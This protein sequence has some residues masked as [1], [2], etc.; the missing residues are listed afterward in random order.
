[1]VAAARDLIEAQGYFGTGVNRVLADSGAPRGSLYFHFPE[2]KDRLVADALEEGGREVDGL[3]AA[4][5]HGE[6]DAASLTRRLLGVLADRM[7][8]SSYD[9]GCPV[10]TVALEVSGTPERGGNERLRE[11]CARIYARWERALAD[12]L[13]AEG[14]PRPEAE[15][16]AGAVLAQIEG[17][18]LLARVRH[19]RAPVDRAARAVEALLAR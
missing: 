16:A 14:R 12:R 13:V 5:E 11:V 7:E 10:A 19:D 3:I 18:L 8:A 4:T 2:G 17:S 6:P 9:K 1:M 15:D